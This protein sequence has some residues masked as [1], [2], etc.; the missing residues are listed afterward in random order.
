MMTNI[1]VRVDKDI[2]EEA[3]NI[4]KRLG[5]NMTEAITLYLKQVIS[6]NGIPFELKLE[7][8]N[9]ETKVAIEEGRRLVND[10][11]TKKYSSIEELKV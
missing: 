5:L 9:E 6:L 10:P 11:K 1:N 3:N 8:P 7:I 2:K 4:F